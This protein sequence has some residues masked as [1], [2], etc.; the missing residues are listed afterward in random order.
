M[1]GG[2]TTDEE[3]EQK[4]PPVEPTRFGWVQGVMV[5]PERQGLYSYSV[6]MLKIQL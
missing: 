5:S 2:D 4:D 3:D 6:Y 1:D